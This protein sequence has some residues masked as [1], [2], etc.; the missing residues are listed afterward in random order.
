[1]ADPYSFRKE[2]VIS[3]ELPDFVAPS[4]SGGDLEGGFLVAPIISR[5]LFDTLCS[6]MEPSMIRVQ[7]SGLNSSLSLLGI[8]NVAVVFHSEEPAMFVW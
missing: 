2:T 1:M 6:K 7:S 3:G 8:S 5:A 4:F